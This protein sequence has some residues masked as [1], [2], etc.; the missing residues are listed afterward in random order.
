[1]MTWAGTPDSD[2]RIMNNHLETGATNPSGGVGTTIGGTVA[3]MFVNAATGAFQ[4][5]G[6]LLTNQKPAIL[7]L[8]AR[9]PVRQALAPAGALA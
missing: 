4:P 8:P 9:G 3:T 7:R 1:V 6:E 2:L 5:A